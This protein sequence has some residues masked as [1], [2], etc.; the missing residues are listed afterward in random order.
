MQNVRHLGLLCQS[1]DSDEAGC[2]TQISE[3]AYTGLPSQWQI[4]SEGKIR[5]I[6]AKQE[7]ALDSKK[8]GLK[9]GGVVAPTAARSFTLSKSPSSSSLM[10]GCWLG[11]SNN[12]LPEYETF[13]FIRPKTLR[14]FKSLCLVDTVNVSLPTN[15]TTYRSKTHLPWLQRP[16][17]NPYMNLRRMLM[18][19]KDLKDGS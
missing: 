11:V 14:G 13:V 8:R 4:D 18:F 1:N 7:I 10:V 3:L 6:K 17:Q 12:L 16:T 9:V 2:L 5:Q 15:R 19:T